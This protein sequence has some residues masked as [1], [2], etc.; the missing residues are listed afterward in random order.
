MS[1]AGRRSPCDYR[2]AK[3]D[4]RRA[5]KDAQRARETHQRRAK[6]DPGQEQFETETVVLVKTGCIV[7]ERVDR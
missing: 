3:K 5:S 6:D 2:R 4:G 1:I 7:N